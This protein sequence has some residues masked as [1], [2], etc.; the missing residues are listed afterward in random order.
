M[1]VN[2]ETDDN[3]STHAAVFKKGKK[4]SVGVICT[5]QPSTPLNMSQD[6]TK[7]EKLQQRVS[8]GTSEKANSNGQSVTQIDACQYNSGLPSSETNYSLGS[9]RV[10]QTAPQSDGLMYIS[11][12]A[13]G[14]TD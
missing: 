5:K 3:M 7:Q 11:D 2:K 13:F 4:G 9:L 1:P 6:L 8:T 14:K 12:Q 10:Y